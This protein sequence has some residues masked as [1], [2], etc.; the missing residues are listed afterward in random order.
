[1]LLF[2]AKEVRCG[3]VSVEL[4]WAAFDQIKG[5]ELIPKIWI[6]VLLVPLLFSDAALA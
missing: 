2:P 3:S 6:H 1:M 4:M 5:L